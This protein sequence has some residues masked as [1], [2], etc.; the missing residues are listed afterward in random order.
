MTTNTALLV[1]ILS[2]I[3]SRKLRNFVRFFLTCCLEFVFYVFAMIFAPE[4]VWSFLPENNIQ[5]K[6]IP[7]NRKLSP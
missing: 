2:L 1:C 7:M 6:P 4:W 3:L 5:P